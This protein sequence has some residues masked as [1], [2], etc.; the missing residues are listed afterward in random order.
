MVLVIAISGELSS[1]SAV[2]VGEA[3]VASRIKVPGAIE[4]FGVVVSSPGVAGVSV[5]VADV[6]VKASIGAS[7]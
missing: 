4:I 3:V 7:V 1:E 2:M 5:T 6:V